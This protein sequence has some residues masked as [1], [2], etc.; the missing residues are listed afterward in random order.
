MAMT[1]SFGGQTENSLFMG[2]ELLPC[3][4]E[5][6]TFGV[7]LLAAD[8]SD[9]GAVG[10]DPW[11]AEIARISGQR[12]DWHFSGGIAHVLFLGDRTKVVTAARIIP[13]PARVMR[14]FKE[15]DPGL[16]R[17]NF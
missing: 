15:G 11:V 2:I 14:W 1:T 9:C 7:S 12:V 4:G 16:Y 13:C 3:D 6:F 17:C 8:T 5:I 10:F